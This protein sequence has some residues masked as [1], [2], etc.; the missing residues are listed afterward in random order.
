[1]VNKA[2]IHGRLVADPETRTTSGGTSVCNFRVAWSRKYKEQEVKLFLPCTAWGS[3]AEIVQNHFSKG[4]EIVLEGELQTNAWQ[5]QNGNRRSNT[6][7]SVDR[8]HFV[9]PKEAT[10]EG[11]PEPPP[12]EP[13]TGE[14]DEDLPF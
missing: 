6:E 3:T 7:L 2:I 14:G 8:V 4:K 13:M 9:G 11:S 1:M 12:L 5:D 10:P